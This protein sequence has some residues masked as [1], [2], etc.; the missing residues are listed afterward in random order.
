MHVGGLTRVWQVPVPGLPWEAA[1]LGEP[2]HGM[3]HMVEH[4]PGSVL[5]PQFRGRWRGS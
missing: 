4:D 3:N 1:F 2:S 5:P